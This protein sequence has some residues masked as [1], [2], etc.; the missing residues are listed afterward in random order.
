MGLCKRFSFKKV[1]HRPIVI[2]SQQYSKCEIYFIHVYI[3][4]SDRI[5]SIEL[6]TLEFNV[7]CGSD[8]F[9]G[10]SNFE[11]YD[12]EKDRSTYCL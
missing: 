2:M 12:K 11:Q 5:Y 10:R 4:L 6:I 3:I 9:Y 7:S 8:K 1:L